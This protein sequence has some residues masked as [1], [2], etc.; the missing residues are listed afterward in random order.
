[1]LVVRCILV[2]STIPDSPASAAPSLSGKLPDLRGG[3]DGER[4]GAAPIELPRVVMRG[5]LAVAAGAL[6]L[7]LLLGLWRAREDMRHELGAALRLADA[8]ALLAERTA[9]ASHPREELL[10]AL[11]ALQADGG[12]RHLHLQLRDAGGRALL[13]DPSEPEPGAPMSWLVALSRSVFPPPARAAVS[14]PLLRPGGEVW[15]LQLQASPE[16]EQRE[17]LGELL[18]LLGLLAL[19]S[20]AMLAVMHWHVRRAFKPLRALLGAIECAER[21]DLAP[22]RDLPAMPIGELDAI[23][24][25]LRHLAGA[26]EQAEAARRHLSGQLLTLQEDERSRLAREL[27][28]E[29]GQ[30]LTAL[31]VDAAWLQRRLAG[32]AELAAVAAGMGAQCEHVQQGVRDLLT[33][34]RPLGA[35]E[36]VADVRRMQVDHAVCHDD[37]DAEPPRESVARLQSL[38]ETLV[39]A[40]QQSP[41]QSTRYALRFQVEGM[42]AEAGLPRALVL[43]VYRISQE[44]LTNVARHASAGHALLE[45]HVRASGPAGEPGELQWSVQDDGRGLGGATAWQRGNGLAGLKERV[46]A[47]GGE[48]EWGDAIAWPAQEGPGLHLHARMPLPPVRERREGRDS[49]D[50][51][52]EREDREDPESRKGREGREGVAP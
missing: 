11:Q 4:R 37:R 51:R 32:Q 34:L 46:W 47:V 24:R 23:A 15:Q 19:G 43:A 27:H 48:L 30:H 40:W 52:E 45:V 29:F 10:A 39:R 28:D 49:P 41:G 36:G 42:G 6:L 9:A 22:L 17:A 13:A 35:A 8:M 3:P 21:R 18:E 14:W 44:A 25:A 7:A 38:L 5:A 1:M 12:L 50:S 2:V 16:A 26:L 31:R 20:A 33:R